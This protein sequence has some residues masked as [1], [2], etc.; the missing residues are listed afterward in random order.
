MGVRPFHDERMLGQ[1]IVITASVA[2]TIGIVAA[3]L[4]FAPYR[5]DFA[6]ENAMPAPIVP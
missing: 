2:S 4:T 3:L 6:A 5:R 1:C